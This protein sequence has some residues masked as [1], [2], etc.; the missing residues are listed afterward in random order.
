MSRGLSSMSYGVG[1]AAR[2]AGRSRAT[3]KR[4]IATGTLSASRTGPGQPWVID[5]AELARVFPAPAHEPTADRPGEPL[6]AGDEPAV[7]A[8]KLE[9]EQAKVAMLERANDDLRRRLD[10]ERAERRQTADR[11]AAA[12]ERIAALLTDQRP[13]VL[14]APARRGWWPWRRARIG[15]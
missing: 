8:A 15:A 7:I 11:L 2:L 10:E 12:Q 1:E 6:R 3:I 9:A 4:M 14:P 13:I 5:A